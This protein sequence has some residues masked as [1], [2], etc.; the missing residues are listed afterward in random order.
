MDGAHT[1]TDAGTIAV[2]V[3]R[4]REEVASSKWFDTAIGAS[5]GVAVLGVVVSTARERWVAAI[6]LVA[7]AALLALLYRWF[8]TLIVEVDGTEVRASFG[9]IR[10]RVP[11]AEIVTIEPERYRWLA[12]GGWGVRYG[13]GRRRA[14]TV[15]FLRQGVRIDRADGRRWYISSRCPDE[16]ALAVRSAAR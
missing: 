14:Y 13:F 9:P 15:P 6:I 7:T 12:Y 3:L 10:A 8:A 4:Y 11:L 16:L 1:A 5:G 2:D